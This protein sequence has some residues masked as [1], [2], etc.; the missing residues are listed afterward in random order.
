MVSFAA[1]DVRPHPEERACR[2][3][4]PNSKA[5]ARVSKDED[6]RLG[7]PSCFETH[8][9]ALGLWKHLRSRPAAT[10]LSMRARE[11]RAFWRNEPN[12]V[13]AKRSQG[14]F[15]HLS[16]PRGAPRDARVAGCPVAG[17]HDHRRWLWVPALP[18]LSRGSAGTT[19]AWSARRINL[20]LCEMTAGAISLFPI[21]INN[22]NCNSNVFGLRGPYHPHMSPTMWHHPS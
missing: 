9:G 13:L 1:R 21:D 16:S 8:R 10:L 6:V 22:G 20:R 2:K 11:R 7:S 17:T 18:S 4:S 5:R 3:T 19:I 15:G 14:S 12:V